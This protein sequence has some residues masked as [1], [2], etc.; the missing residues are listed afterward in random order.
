[1]EVQQPN[2]KRMQALTLLEAK[3]EET[4]KRINRL[5]D[6]FEEAGLVDT[7]RGKK[8]LAETGRSIYAQYRSDKWSILES[9]LTSEETE[10][11]INKGWVLI[12]R[13]DFGKP[14]PVLSVMVV[15]HQQLRIEQA[16]KAAMYI[17]QSKHFTEEEKKLAKVIAE[18]ISFAIEDGVLK[19]S[20]RNHKLT[21]ILHPSLRRSKKRE[22]EEKIDEVVSEFETE[23]AKVVPQWYEIVNP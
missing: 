20:L 14:L 8:A 19:G 7:R 21:A 23:D 3:Q 5:L 15:P 17:A 4:G 9:Q 18:E 10:K 2:T 1:M 12:K 11:L 22:E 6:I 16:E 13:G